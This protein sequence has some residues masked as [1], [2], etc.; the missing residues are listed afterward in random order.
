MV[1]Y[2]KFSLLIIVDEKIITIT[3]LLKGLILLAFITFLFFKKN[4][5]YYKIIFVVA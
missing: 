4:C 2:Y 1:S 3:A 5:I